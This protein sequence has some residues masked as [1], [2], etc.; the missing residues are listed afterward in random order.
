MQ[1][2]WYFDSGPFGILIYFVIW[3]IILYI[4]PI[5]GLLIRC[6]WRE[7]NLCPRLAGYFQL[8][9]SRRI[10]MDIYRFCTMNM[11]SFRIYTA[12]MGIFMLSTVPG[13]VVFVV[14]I[15][16][17]LVYTHRIAEY[18]YGV[19]WLVVLNI[20]GVLCAATLFFLS[21]SAIVNFSILLPSQ[22]CD[23]STVADQM[24]DINFWVSNSE[25]E[26]E[27]LKVVLKVLYLFVSCFYDI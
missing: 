18:Q 25:I 24:V 16:F 9:T 15:L 11:P 26:G 1:G 5:L 4:P 12:H 8:Y 13:M 19:I 20:Y 23:H 22:S 10:S 2:Y 21:Y 17:P 27:K 6:R 7:E 14:M 3:M